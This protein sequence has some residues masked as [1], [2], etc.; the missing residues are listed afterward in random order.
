MVTSSPSRPHRIYP[1]YTGRD[2]NMAAKAARD[3]M[4]PFVLASRCKRIEVT[5]FSPWP[6]FY[7]LV[8]DRE[9]R[10]RYFEAERLGGLEVHAQFE[11]GWQCTGRSPGFSPLRMRPA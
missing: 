9:Q 7:H 6:L 10:R 3:P 2:A 4:Q 8:G 5:T 11:L 1:G